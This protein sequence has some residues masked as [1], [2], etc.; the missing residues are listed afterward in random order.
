MTPSSNRANTIKFLVRL[1]AQF[2]T[3][4]EMA[5]VVAKRSNLYQTSKPSKGF[6]LHLFGKF[7]KMDLWLALNN[8]CRL[9]PQ[10]ALVPDITLINRRFNGTPGLTRALDFRQTII[11]GYETGVSILHIEWIPHGVLGSKKYKSETTCQCSSVT[12]NSV[13]PA[14]ISHYVHCTG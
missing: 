10:P 6:S 1:L 9:Y 12:Y 5:L 7:Q 11:D 8:Q 3:H 2:G 4:L 14:V 13:P